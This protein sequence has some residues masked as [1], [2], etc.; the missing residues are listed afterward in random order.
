VKDPR[1]LPT[2]RPPRGWSV[3]VGLRAADEGEASNHVLHAAT[4]PMTTQHSDYGSDIAERL[5]VDDAL[6]VLLEFSAPAA[7]TALF[8]AQGLPLPTA[9]QFGPQQLQRTLA[10]QSGYQRFFTTDARPFCLYVVLGSHSRRARTV[11]RV[12]ALLATI[13]LAGGAF[14]VRGTS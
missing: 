14:T 6:V 4:I 12:H 3:R 10:G 9:A 7:R 2:L 5:G 11:P 1:A 8:A 13:D